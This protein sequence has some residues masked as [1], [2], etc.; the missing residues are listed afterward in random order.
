MTKSWVLILSLMAMVASFG[1]L[2][3]SKKTAPST[4][5]TEMKLG[6]SHRPSVAEL[7]ALEEKIGYKFKN[8]QLLMDALTHASFS[9][10]NN[11]VLNILG[12]KVVQQAA[13]AHFILAD[14][15]I[16]KGNLEKL[17]AETCNAKAC[18]S[19]ALAL[20]LEPLIMVGKGIPKLNDKI[21]SGAFNAIYGGIALDDGPTT[22]NFAY[23]KLKEWKKATDKPATGSL[24]L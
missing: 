3:D 24:L 18:A 8:V 9:E 5:A 7:S 23:W 12:S 21:L 10:A 4:M 6:T 15:H 13:A 22:A 17:I 2:A 1:G 16:A 19:D 11:D 14:P 20:K